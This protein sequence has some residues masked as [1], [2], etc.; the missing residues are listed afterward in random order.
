MRQLIG[1]VRRQLPFDLPQ[2]RLCNGP[3]TGC[4]LKLLD[5][6]EVELQ[7]WERRL[8]A[9]A[10]ALGSVALETGAIIEGGARVRDSVLLEGARVAAGAR[11]ERCVVDAGVRVPGDATIRDSV[12]A[13][14]QQKGVVTYPLG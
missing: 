1:E 7:A 6:L 2:A 10:E 11:L 12:V 9:G 3:C 8:D 14:S 13:E 4:S 5:F